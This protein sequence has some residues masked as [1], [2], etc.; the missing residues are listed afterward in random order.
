[1]KNPPAS[2][3][4]LLAMAL[5]ALSIEAAEET[6]ELLSA[7]ETIARFEGLKDHRCLGMPS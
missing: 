5:P 4:L 7:H 6:R 2:L 3:I 1:M